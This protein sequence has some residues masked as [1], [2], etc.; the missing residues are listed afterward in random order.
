MGLAQQTK[1][2]ILIVFIILAYALSVIGNRIIIMNIDVNVDTYFITSQKA[3]YIFGL[4]FTV[5]LIYIFYTLRKSLV[6]R[7][8]LIFGII[9]EL[10]IGVVLLSGIID[11][12][13]VYIN[14]I[15]QI[16][17]VKIIIYLVLL[18]IALIKKEKVITCVYITMFLLMNIIQRINIV[19]VI[20]NGRWLQEEQMIII[21]KVFSFFNFIYSFGT[22]ILIL[23][24][25]Y[26]YGEL[27]KNNKEVKEI[28]DNIESN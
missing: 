10:F 18:I 4:P 25:F 26:K 14:F 5:F 11:S 12:Y 17:N 13:E 20:V 6:F 3:I 21:F 2:N 16:F 9:Q 1:K 22:F 24:L 27:S 7:I 15:Y 19:R 23:I 28:E 8:L